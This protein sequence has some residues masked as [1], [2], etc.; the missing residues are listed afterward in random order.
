MKY[1]YLIFIFLICIF[2]TSC[3]NSKKECLP[4][5][6][7]ITD[8][9]ESDKPKLSPQE[10]IE[11]VINQYF[12]ETEFETLDEENGLVYKFKDTNYYIVYENQV[13]DGMKNYYS[14][15]VYESVIND[16]ESHI[17]TYNWYKVDVETGEILPMFIFDESGEVYINENY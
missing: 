11:L 7:D 1:R 8:I 16:E 5:Q 3:K 13:Q 15:R 9:I 17:A 2:A 10:A 12:D 4:I 6:T 14:I